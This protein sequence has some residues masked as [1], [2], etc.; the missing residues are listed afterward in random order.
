MNYQRIYD[1]LIN[2]AKN[3]NLTGYFEKHH[4]MPKCLG[5]TDCKT[6]L[7]NLTPEEHYLA[8]QLLIKI[9]PNNSK[10]VYAAVMMIPNRPSNKLYGWIKRRQSESI[11][12]SQSGESNSQHN[13][14]WISNKT[15]G[16]SKKISKLEEIPLG[17]EVGRIVKW[18]SYKE[19]IYD[20]CRVCGKSKLVDRKFCSISCASTFNNKNKKTIFDEHLEEIIKDY[21][22]GI[23]IHK[24]LISRNL[25]GTG[26]NFTTLKKI[27]E[28]NGGK[29]I[30][31]DTSL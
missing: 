21:S 22:S 28:S 7:V 26:K 5:G 3:R 29:S 4:I 11:S 12:K 13:T 16:I 24:C 14:I 30:G 18:D 9:Y 23:S 10:L 6:N 20:S 31:A 17:W 15:L 1:N 8:H 25:C 2:K 19:P 27:L